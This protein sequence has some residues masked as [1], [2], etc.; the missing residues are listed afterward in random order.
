MGTKARFSGRHLVALAVAETL[1]W[2]GLYYAF[3]ALLVH[4]ETDLGWSKTELAG[5]FT[6]AL[7]VSAITAPFAGRLIDRG[8]GRLV[9]VG[10]TL[11]GGV[12]MI[13][14]S[15]VEQSVTFYVVWAMIGLSVAGCLYEP[16]FAY[17]T[18]LLGEEAR[19][20]ITRI[21]LVAGFAGTVSFPMANAIAQYQGWRVASVAFGALIVLVAAPLFVY[22]TS[23]VGANVNAVEDSA[24][25]E[26]AA[27]R[28]L[29][30]ATFWLLAFAFSMVGLTHGI[31][32]THLMPMLS[33]W[34]V[35][36]ALGVLAASMIGP[37]Q[38][39]GRIG[40]IA[41]ETRVSMQAICTISFLFMGGA[42][43]SLIGAA[44]LPALL[45]VFVV[46]HGSGYGATS[47]TRPVVTSEILGRSGFGAIS[48]NLAF[49][50][51]AA[52]AVAPALAAVIWEFGGYDLVRLVALACVGVG[53]LAFF[54]ATRLVETS[55]R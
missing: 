52:S 5:A 44:V 32:I 37:M 1:V 43:L 4:W 41:V 45:V 38:V 9:L 20:V 31:V 13:C 40:M 24:R 34:G 19:K 11:L 18:R 48:G 46:L 29:R 12:L 26:K 10:G 7:I 50:F 53:G 16:C 25:D 27:R 28:A 42:I 22:G 21:T 14:L 17:V 8:H 2:A 39:L 51:M 35:P 36:L 15:F 3:P 47:I 23:A 33:E 6:V 55:S 30:R 49:G 54:I